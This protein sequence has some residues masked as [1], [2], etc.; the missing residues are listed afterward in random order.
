MRK[1][2]KKKQALV[3]GGIVLLVLMVGVILGVNKAPRVGYCFEVAF[4]TIRNRLYLAGGNRGLHVL[5]IS[6]DGALNFT[7]TNFDGG[8]Y[9]NIDIS[10]DYGYIANSKRGLQVL[11]IRGEI[12]ETIWT[13]TNAKGYG[14]DIQD[15]I[16]FMVGND[17][18]LYVFDISNP[19]DPQLLSNFTDL[20]YVWDIWVQGD[21][22]YI[23]D[24]TVGMV[25]IDISDPLQPRRA[26]EV[27]WHE[28]ETVSEVIHGE[29]DF[30]YVAAGS[31]GLYIIDISNP[32]TPKI[33]SHIDPGL[34]G[35]TEG[36]MVRDNVV[37]VSVHNGINYFKNGLYIYN[38]DDPSQPELV[39][40][41]PLT[42]MVED[43]TLSGN[44]L[45][46]ANTAS[47]VVFFDVENPEKPKTLSTFPSSFWRLFTLLMW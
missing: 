42:D 12:P 6:Q 25:V 30:A 26:G 29:G 10:G 5:E 21:Y 16:V 3:G 4:D 23:A 1:S 35:A 17:E 7:T 45:A 40:K 47:G 31:Q 38:V 27:T 39:S 33:S 43:V 44:Y 20:E 14:L 22:A 34:F 32:V 9:R 24:F 8:Y 41:F 2:R 13:Q 36:V 11:D 19:A 15:D 46:L 18:G 28:G 37:Y